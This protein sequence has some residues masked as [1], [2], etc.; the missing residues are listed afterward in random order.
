MLRAQKLNLRNPWVV[1][2]LLG[3]FG[4]SIHEGV[5]NLHAEERNSFRIC[6][7]LA[8]D[9]DGDNKEGVEGV[10]DGDL[11]KVVG[12]TEVDAVSGDVEWLVNCVGIHL[13]LPLALG[14]EVADDATE[15]PVP[16]RPSWEVEHHG[17]H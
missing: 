6:C 10:V 3:H 13:Q 5:A 15:D 16:C 4:D 7:N 17:R 11:A 8:G 12:K 1:V 9:V 2:E 14:H